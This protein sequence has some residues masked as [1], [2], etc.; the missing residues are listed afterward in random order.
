M[1]QWRAMD[2]EQIIHRPSGREFMDN[3]G[4]FFRNG[5]CTAS[6]AATLQNHKLRDA[7]S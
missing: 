4:R 1:K 5:T 6:Y 3:F 2:D 7:N